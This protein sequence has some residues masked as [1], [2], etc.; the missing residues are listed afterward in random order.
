MTVPANTLEK[1]NSSRMF[2]VQVFHSGRGLGSFMYEIHVNLVTL[3]VQKT[4]Q[5]MC[6]SGFSFDL[7]QCVDLWSV[8]PLSVCVC[9]CV[10]CKIRIY[11]S[12]SSKSLEFVCSS[13]CKAVKCA[14]ID[15]HMLCEWTKPAGLLVY[16]VCAIVCGHACFFFF[17]FSLFSCFSI[18]CYVTAQFLPSLPPS[19][20]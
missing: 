14:R 20:L 15:K 1:T 17:C 11:S 7:L 13:V 8:S 2:V 6:V 3:A 10:F 16:F 12:L 4:L 9:S 18:R 19:F 5:G